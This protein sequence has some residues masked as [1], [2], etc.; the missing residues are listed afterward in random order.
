MAKRKD[1]DAPN[2]TQFN[3]NDYMPDAEEAQLEAGTLSGDVR[4]VLLTHIRSMTVPW[5]MLNEEEQR[6]K[7]S[8]ISKCAEDLVRKAIKVVTAQNFPTI[9]VEVKEW[10]VKGGIEMKCG[11]S[12]LIENI[13]S[14][15]EH[16]PSPAV[17]VLA[18]ASGFFGERAKARAD[19]DQKSLPLTDEDDE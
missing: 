3:A 13:H 7:I 12:A 2:G 6:D 9:I 8:A 16:G 10:K 15:A 4:D 11:A 5:A 14:L 17:L 19:K 1:D 18:E